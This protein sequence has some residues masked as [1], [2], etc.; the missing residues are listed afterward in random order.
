[1]TQEKNKSKDS[2]SSDSF[3]PKSEVRAIRNQIVELRIKNMYRNNAQVEKKISRLLE[4]L[5]PIQTVK[6]KPTYAYDETVECFKA[7]CGQ[8]VPKQYWTPRKVIEEHCL[9]CK[10]CNVLLG[11]S[12]QRKGFTQDEVAE[13]FLKDYECES[14]TGN[15]YNEKGILWHYQTI[16]AIKT[17]A[18]K[19][20]NNLDCWN[21]G[22]ARCTTPNRTDADI[23][24][25]TFRQFVNCRNQELRE[26]T[27]VDKK[28][29]A[30]LFKWRM[31]YFLNATDEQRFIVELVQPSKTIDEAY[32]SM[33]P[34]DVKRAERF[35]YNEK[36]LLGLKVERQGDFFFIPTPNVTDSD[37]QTIDKAIM[38]KTYEKDYSD[39]QFYLVNERLFPE[40]EL[41][42][43]HTVTRLGKLGRHTYVKGIVRHP[44]H[45]SLKLGDI[46]HLVAKNVVKDSISVVT[47][48][49]TKCRLKS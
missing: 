43:R 35:G 12:K 47:E 3:L 30:V 17:K 36:N 27:L 25:T 1:M 20:I 14:G 5:Y 18:G 42:S 45:R 7:V 15:F 10:V 24:L 19:I 22:F 23:N 48:G 49:L 41:G 4:T 40:L 21:R 8:T 9:S 29:S 32:E 31:R 44:Q 39:D 37:M 38:H 6:D 26:I 16:E 33:K 2:S 28:G 46:W 13:L 11:Y 34:N